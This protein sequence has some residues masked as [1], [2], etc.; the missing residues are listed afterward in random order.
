MF[1]T[2][3]VKL[4]LEAGASQFFVRDAEG[5]TPLQLAVKTNR[6]AIAAL[7]AEAGPAEALTLEDG[8][9]NTPREVAARQ[10]FLAQLDVACG[11]FPAPQNLQLNYNTRPFADLAAREL[12]LPR[13]RATIDA[14]LHEG[15]LAAGTKLTKELITF[16]DRLEAKIALEKKREAEQESMEESK[17]KN[18]VGTKVETDIGGTASEVLEVLNKALDARPALRQLVHLSD[19]HESVTKSLE[20]FGKKQKDHQKFRRDAEDDGLPEEPEVIESA[21]TQGWDSLVQSLTSRY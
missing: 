8:V 20:Q 11:N 6:P 10:A 15:R 3:I 16:A 5:Y 4:F 19:V 21:L 9:G 12:E 13:L 2:D 7:L 17:A 14:L 1:R 18:D